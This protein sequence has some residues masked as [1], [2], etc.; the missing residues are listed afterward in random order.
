MVELSASIV[1]TLLAALCA[2]HVAMALGAP[3]GEPAFSAHPFGAK[4]AARGARLSPG[5]RA[6]SGIAA[7]VVAGAA[8]VVSA[9]GGVV[10]DGSVD[11]GLL[12]GLTWLTGGY[13]LVGAVA[14]LGSAIEA[15]RRLG[16]AV[17]VLIALGCAVVALGLG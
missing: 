16:G 10:P 11:Q 6:V 8:W 3:W 15:K 2:Y 4:P 7:A 5:Y 14:N 12:A 17:K 9:R 1:A 13:F